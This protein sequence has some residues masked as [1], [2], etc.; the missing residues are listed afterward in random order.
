MAKLK[1][2]EVISSKPVVIFDLFHTLTS[3]ESTGRVEVSADNA[4][5]NGSQFS[6]TWSTGPTTS[7]L[8]G[9]SNDAWIEQLHEKSRQRLAGAWKDPYVFIE[10]MA[11]AI[12][13]DISSEV[14]RVAVENRI[15]RFASA[16][17]DIPGQSADVLKTLKG[18]GRKLGLISN[19]DVTEV[20]AWDQSPI[21]HL[22]DSTVFSC[23]AGFVKP[24]RQIYDVCLAELGVSSND[25]VYVGDGGSDE[26]KGARSLG[27]TTVMITGEVERLWPD[28]LDVRKKDADYVIRELSELL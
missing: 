22:F 2:S 14:I 18:R 3:L 8:L 16:M 11:H 12:D 15:N 20:A 28:K 25:C 5:Q 7:Q 1:L 10:K 17:R 13:P 19:A 9:V 24:E 23:V 6:E 4:L 26:L 27:M 21:A